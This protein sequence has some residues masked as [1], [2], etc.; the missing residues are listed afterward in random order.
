M[1]VS[2]REVP[3]VGSHQCQN[4]VVQCLTYE[5][6]DPDDHLPR[7]VEPEYFVEFQAHVEGD[8]T[9]LSYCPGTL[10]CR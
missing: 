4:K 9:P 5:T 8:E 1:G 6:P 2:A 10:Q 7:G 3:E